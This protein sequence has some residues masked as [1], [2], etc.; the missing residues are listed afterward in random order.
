MKKFI[1]ILC[2]VTFLPAPA[3]ARYPDS[4]TSQEN[5]KKS[6]RY[7]LLA[8]MALSSAAGLGYIGFI[9]NNPRAQLVFYPIT[10]LL[11]TSAIVL[12]GVSQYFGSKVE[13]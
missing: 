13:R 6:K 5:Y 8:L 10:G 4:I 11:A 3:L 1:F 12:V 7:G 9:S 2:L